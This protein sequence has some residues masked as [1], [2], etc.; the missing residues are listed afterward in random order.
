MSRDCVNPHAGAPRATRSID[1]LPINQR[2]GKIA[3]DGSGRGPHAVART[4]NA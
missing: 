1:K 3:Q 4:M 2:A